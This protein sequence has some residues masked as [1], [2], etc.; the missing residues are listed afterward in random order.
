VSIASR[1]FSHPQLPFEALDSEKGSY[2]KI[3][4]AYDAHALFNSWRWTDEIGR[5][6]GSERRFTFAQNAGILPFIVSSDFQDVIGRKLFCD[7]YPSV[8]PFAG[9]YDDMPTW[10][11]MSVGI[12]ENA[13]N[14]ASKYMRRINGN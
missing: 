14:E 7:K 1:S 12:I 11:I 4:S 2:V 13:T 8:P 10:W 5:T 6:L 9:S 3:N